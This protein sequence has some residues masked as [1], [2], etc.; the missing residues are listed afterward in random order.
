M[1]LDTEDSVINDSCLT[2]YQK[3]VK[4]AKSE[5]LSK[6]IN[7][8]ANRPRMLFKTINLVLNPLP[9]LLIH[10]VK[11]VRTC[12]FFFYDKV[13]DIKASFKPSTFDRPV[14]CLPTDLLTSFH[15][16]SS[17]QLADI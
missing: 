9:F 3:S 2:R 11:P 4:E 13:L 6:R 15:P 14:S 1:T 7:E 17:I 16:I 8:N 12:R 10:L 5:F